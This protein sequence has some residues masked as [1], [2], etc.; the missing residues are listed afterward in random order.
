MIKRVIIESPYAGDVESNTTYA[1]E[2]LS[3]SL[4]RGEAPLASHLL[5]TQ[6]GVLNDNIPNEREKGITAGLSWLPYAQE[7]IFYLDRGFSNGMKEALF[8]SIQ[9]GIKIS[10]RTINSKTCTE[11]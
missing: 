5:Y 9:L 10:F 8:Q 6:K 2:A 3:D 7:H 4:Q 1:R 11:A